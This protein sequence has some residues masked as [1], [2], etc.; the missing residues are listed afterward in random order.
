MSLLLQIEQSLQA[1]DVRFGVES[2]QLA[3]S[4]ERYLLLIEKWNRVHNLT[5]IRDPRDMLIQHVLDSLVVL[6]HIHG[7]QIV[8]VGTGAGLPGIPIALARPDWQVTLVE[9]N[10]KKTAFLQQAKIELKL[11]NVQIMAQRIEQVEAKPVNTI[12]SRAFSELGEF[13]ALTR[14]WAAANSDCRWV[15]MKAKCSDQER[16]QVQAPFA[17]ENIVTLHVPGLDAMRQLIIIKHEQ[18]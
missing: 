3:E 7:P 12:I 6:P 5:A 14:Q 9:S 15:A 16:R 13:I 11:H 1:L 10:Q 8:D 18:P 17:I 2:R 4:I